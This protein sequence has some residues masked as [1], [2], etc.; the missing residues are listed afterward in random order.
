[1]DRLPAAEQIS[2]GAVAVV[3]HINELRR[4]P[5]GMLNLN[6]L[7]HTEA[8][9][10]QSAHTKTWVR[11]KGRKKNPQH[12][13]A[14]HQRRDLFQC[15]IFPKKKG[16]SFEGEPV[17]WPFSTYL[18]HILPHVFK[19]RNYF[20]WNWSKS[21]Y[22]LWLQPWFFFLFFFFYTL[23]LCGTVMAIPD[24]QLCTKLFSLWGLLLLGPQKYPRPLSL[25]PVF[26][27]FWFLF[28]FFFKRGG[29]GIGCI[30][31][32]YFEHLATT[33]QRPYAAMT[34]VSN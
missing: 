3:V 23:P 22:A 6:L 24:S 16:K 15:L 7:L 13:V 5:L 32:F 28:I 2:G 10:I 30:S 12:T 34:N 4:P 17:M 27:A 33:Q 8:A 9:G 14:M 25:K 20:C 18:L 21:F 1:M 31:T 29:A 26:I 19:S 11:G